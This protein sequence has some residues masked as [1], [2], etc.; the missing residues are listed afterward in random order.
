[1]IVIETN[2]SGDLERS[3]DQFAEKLRGE[4]LISAAAAMARPI[5]EELLTRASPERNNR[6]RG[7]R[8]KGKR[9]GTLQSAVY[10]T[11]SESR[12]DNDT[13]AYHV[14]VNKGKAPHW[15]FLEYGTSHQPAYPFIRPSYDAKID[16]AIAAGLAHLKEKFQER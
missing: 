14:G 4:A 1:M 3:I 13:K 10:R 15:H 2:L 5:Y 16:E 11:L 12:S 8:P 7:R 9:P 6:A